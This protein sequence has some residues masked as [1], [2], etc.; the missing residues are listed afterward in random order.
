MFLQEIVRVI[1]QHVILCL[2]RP[3]RFL[4][5]LKRIVD[6][7]PLKGCDEFRRWNENACDL[8]AR[9]TDSMSVV[10]KFLD[11]IGVRYLL[12]IIGFTQDIS[13]VIPL[14]ACSGAVLHPSQLEAHDIEFLNHF[15]SCRLD[16]WRGRELVL[17][18]LLAQNLVAV[19][20][21]H[22]LYA[23]DK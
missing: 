5:F 16:H 2:Y 10:V 15:P 17:S 1:E 22:V 9:N 18:G 11:Q 3:D 13:N 19:L 21:T 14:V 4:N 20:L 8:S 12:C 6:L 23:F 7:A